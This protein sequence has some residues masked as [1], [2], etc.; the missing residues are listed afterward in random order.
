[1]TEG[2]QLNR[3]TSFPSG[4]QVTSLAKESSLGSSRFKTSP[5]CKGYRKF[6][7]RFRV[8]IPPLVVFEDEI[9]ML[10]KYEV[11]FGVIF[12]SEPPKSIIMS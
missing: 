11:S 3:W 7:V 10:L 12:N 6:M 1:M 2:A 9:I 8:P 5:F 4:K